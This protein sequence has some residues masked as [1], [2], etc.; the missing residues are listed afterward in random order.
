MKSREKVVSET[1][2]IIEQ[3]SMLG[4]LKMWWIAKHIHQVEKEGAP[5]E[6]KAQ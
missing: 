5:W 1:L 6:K 3:L 4:V 2:E